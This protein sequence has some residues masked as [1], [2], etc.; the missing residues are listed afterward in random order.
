MSRAPS[1]LPGLP[2]GW[3]VVRTWG[4]GNEVTRAVLARADG[5]EVE[6]SSRRHR[7]RLGLQPV[8]DGGPHRS[9][10]P[11]PMSWWM[12][13][14]F[15]AGSLCFALGSLP[16]YFDDVSPETLALT[17]FVGSVLFTGAGALQFR[18]ALHA[19]TDVVRARQG[20]T[21]GW[22]TRPIDWWA[23]AIQLVGT[24]CFNVSTFAATRTGFTE[25][26]ERRL[27]WAPDLA[28]SICFFVASWLAYAEA[29]TR[30]RPRP[31][32]S[33]G[34]WIAAVNLAGS[35]AFGAAAIGARY[36]RTT[37]EPANIALV[38]A[39]TFVGALCFLTGAALLPVESAEAVPDA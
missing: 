20:A 21:R 7:K 26:Q 4:P 6:W 33:V 27:I 14:L 31:D 23:T 24:L 3:R 2:A 22:R 11:S 13:G 10:R 28:G 16:G 39:G 9:G 38:N 25:G 29:N 1:A 5:T 30:I 37:D 15:A 32:R 18:E 17:F 12:G 34:W 8:G 36:L 35:V 19:P